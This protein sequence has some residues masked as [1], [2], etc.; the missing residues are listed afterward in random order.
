MFLIA[1]VSA[2]YADGAGSRGSFTRGGW[3][4]GRYVAMG[5]TGEVT[6]DDVYAI[7]WNPAG[8]VALQNRKRLSAEEIKE[9]A[10]KGDVDAIPEEDLLNFSED[11]YDRSVYQVGASASIL[12]YDRQAAFGGFACDMFGGIFGV[13]M[14]SIMSTGIQG[15]DSTGNP[16]TKVN[17][18]AAEPIV[19]YGYGFGLVRVGGSIKGLF[20]HI[21]NVDYTGCGFDLGT[22]VDLLPFL[23]LGF[24]LQDI[25]SG[26]FPVKKEGGVSR[27]YDL[28]SP[29]MKLGLSI[30]SDS[31][32]SFA[33]GIVK[34]LEQNDFGIHAGVQY[35]VVR[36]MQ[37][38]LGVNGECFSTG[39][40]LRFL[41]IG[42]SYAIAMDKIGDGYNNT[43]SF[44][45]LF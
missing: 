23:R 40:T 2:L 16:T 10:R 11:T 35:Q 24:M 20:E 44:S 17:Y 15:Y 3:A 33:I 13:G 5:G 41:N 9:K 14:Y 32:I 29:S 42:V 1:S 26:L 43:L 27:R 25:G 39:V 4:G 31:G 19:S 28:L 8:L 6:A 38:Y 18:I 21:G 37:V 22:Q 30:A 7:Y 45:M 12:E 34:K 36:F